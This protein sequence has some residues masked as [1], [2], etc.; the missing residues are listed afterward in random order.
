MDITKISKACVA[1]MKKGGLLKAPED[2]ADFIAAWQKLIPDLK[3]GDSDLLL[4]FGLN[5]IFK[6]VSKRNFEIGMICHILN[7]KYKVSFWVIADFFNRQWNLDI[8]YSWLGRL[9][10]AV[11]LKMTHASLRDIGDIDRLLI[12]SN[13]PEKHLC[14]VSRPMTWPV[15]VPLAQQI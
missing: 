15:S 5:N 12:L 2:K 14:C 13:L 10:K 6:E 1:E 9:A 8:T 4:L 11:S 7:E 3:E